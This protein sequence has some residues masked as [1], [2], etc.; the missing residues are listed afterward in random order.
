MG[1][2]LRSDSG[3]ERRETGSVRIRAQLVYISYIYIYMRVCVYVCV[4]AGNT[5]F[6]LMLRAS[7]SVFKLCKSNINAKPVINNFLASRREIRGWRRGK[8]AEETRRSV[9][10]KD[11]FYEKRRKSERE[12]KRGILRRWEEVILYLPWGLQPSPSRTRW[13]STDVVR[14]FFHTFSRQGQWCIWRGE[15]RGTLRY[16]PKRGGGVL[17]LR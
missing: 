16:P 11:R 6:M 2:R 1:V 14:S 12:K 13:E 5:I 7:G 4:D 8:G 9:R 10:R 3:K 17:T 15:V